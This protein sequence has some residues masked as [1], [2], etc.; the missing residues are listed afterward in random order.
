MNG[1]DDSDVKI[2]DRTGRSAR[3]EDIDTMAFIEETRLQRFNGNTAKAKLL[4]RG[5]VSAFSYK[6]A[7]EEL[8]TALS[9][10][11]IEPTEK[12]MLQIKFLSVFS[13]EYS[14]EHFLPSQHLSAV[15]VDEMY[16]VMRENEPAF[17]DDLARSSAFS[18]Y[19]LCARDSSD[20]ASAVAAQFAKLCGHADDERFVS[21][22]RELFEVNVNVF[23]RAVG[24]FVFA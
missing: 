10:H 8:F 3:T 13:A 11:G 12:I 18:F 22:G 16:D 6:S 20:L 1:F 24:G 7:P 9:R 19:Y 5:I 14:L 23:C 4:G 17:F 2:V 21:L 15:A